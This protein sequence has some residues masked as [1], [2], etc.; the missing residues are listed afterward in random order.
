[1]RDEDIAREIGDV[2]E[3]IEAFERRVELIAGKAR[4]ELAG[5]AGIYVYI[6]ISYRYIY[7]DMYIHIDI[8]IEAFDRR[9][10]LIAGKARE[11]LAGDAGI[12][13]YV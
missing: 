11:E 6:D 10:E 7:I 8:Y 12:Y 5:D 9:V 4:E 1:V 3:Q 2:A 13:L